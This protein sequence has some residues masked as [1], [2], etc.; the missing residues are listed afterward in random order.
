MLIQQPTSLI[1]P[2]SSAISFKTPQ[3]LWTGSKPNITHLRSFRCIAYAQHLD[4]KLNPRA[5]KC[6]M[7][8]YLEGVKGYKLLLIQHG[9]YKVITSRDVTFNENDSH[10]KRL[11]TSSIE[12]VDREQRQETHFYVSDAYVEPVEEEFDI[13]YSPKPVSDSDRNPTDMGIFGNFEQPDVHSSAED[14]AHQS[15]GQVNSELSTNNNVH[16]SNSD[17]DLKMLSLMWIDWL[18]T[19]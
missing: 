4:G 10:F 3:E 15:S 8:G 1:D 2:P 7:L 5:Q 11:L 13:G 6:V 12:N 18:I 17:Y 16:D 9:G 14:Q 19:N